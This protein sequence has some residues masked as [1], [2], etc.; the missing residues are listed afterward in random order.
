M[1]YFIAA[2][3]DISTRDN[4]NLNLEEITLLTNDNYSKLYF[5]YYIVCQCIFL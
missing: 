2:F 3:H 4:E 1:R 5:I